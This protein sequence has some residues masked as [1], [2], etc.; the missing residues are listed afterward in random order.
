MTREFPRENEAQ[1]PE[2]DLL[3]DD[4]LTWIDE[5]D[6]EPQPTYDAGG[7]SDGGCHERPSPG[8][9]HAGAE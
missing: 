3:L 1:E 5:H 9:S 8:R 6:N 4:F 7:S 2:M